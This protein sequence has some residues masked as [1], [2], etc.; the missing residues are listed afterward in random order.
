MLTWWHHPPKTSRRNII[1]FPGPDP[2]PISR[3]SSVS[4]GAGRAVLWAP[5]AEDDVGTES[6]LTSSVG[7]ERTCRHHS[8]ARIMTNWVNTKFTEMNLKIFLSCLLLSTSSGLEVRTDGGYSEVVVRLEDGLHH[9]NCSVILTNIQSFLAAS[10]S[11]LFSA[12][13][14][15]FY[16]SEIFSN[17][18]AAIF[19]PW[20]IDSHW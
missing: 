12:L 19:S 3:P 7:T 13:A 17:F 10:S 16:L 18:L 4:V 1:W 15:K 20:L 6:Q 2:R 8:P 5:P 9:Q 11:S 14:G